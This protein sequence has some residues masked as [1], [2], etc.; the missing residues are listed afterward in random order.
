MNRISAAYDHCE[1]VIK[2]HSKTFFR[3]F[4]LLPK[5]QRRAVWAVYAFCRKA[6]DIVDE[7]SPPE[8]LDRFE[9]DLSPFLKGLLKSNRFGLP[10][11][12]SS[13]ASIWT[14]KRSGI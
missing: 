12:M 9:R 7:G 1:S 10:S 14:G 13:S 11:M 3:A 8:V 2:H 4:S 6:D 5:N